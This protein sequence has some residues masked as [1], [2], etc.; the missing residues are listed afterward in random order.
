MP[1][2]DLADEYFNRSHLTVRG[3][4]L[5]HTRVCYAVF[6]R[7]AGRLA[8]VADVISL[9]RHR[10]GPGVVVRGKSDGDTFATNEVVLSIEGP[11]GQLVTLETEYLGMLSMSGAASN[12][13]AMV[14]A[15]GEVKIIDMAARHFPP[16]LAGRIGVAAAIGGAAGT[17]TPAGYAEARA[18]FGVGGRQIQV[19]AAP[20]RDFKLYG[21]IPHALNAVYAGSSIESAAAYHERFPN[22]PL[23]VLVDFE[24]TER[25]TVS[26]AVQRF[27][28]DLFAVRLDTPMSRVHQGGHEKPSRALEMRILSKV[29]DR[30]AAMA[31]L[32][33]YGFGPGVTIEAAYAIRDLLDSLCAR[34]TKLI[35]S[36]GFDLE[37]IRAFKAC[38]APMDFIGTGSWIQFFT[39]TSDIVRVY[40]NDTWQARCKVGRA[41]E[42]HEP[43]DMPVLLSS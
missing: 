10:G 22:V 15:A 42:L 40:E 38:A 7:S 3:T 36:S 8:G 1:V 23:T 19:G 24:G 17:S 21:T 28:G 29:K 43:A 13:A 4:P 16:E 34:E 12:M 20:P 14:E 6:C 18:R 25:D 39:F 32:E 31:A 30:P 26:A 5:E 9:I 27:H 33:K 35:V 2:S 11:F 41:A 37:K